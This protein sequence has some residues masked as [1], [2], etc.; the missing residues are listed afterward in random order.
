M[1]HIRPVGYCGCR[2]RQFLLPKEEIELLEGYK[3]QLQREIEGVEN[4]IKE[5]KR[6]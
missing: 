5:L 6:K 1:P 3:Q 4:R 2:F